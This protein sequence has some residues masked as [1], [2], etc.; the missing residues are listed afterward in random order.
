MMGEKANMV[1]LIIVECNIYSECMVGIL[2]V[3]LSQF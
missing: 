1:M 2:S 3:H